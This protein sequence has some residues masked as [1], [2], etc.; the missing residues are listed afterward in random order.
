MPNWLSD[1]SS[2]IDFT[3]AIFRWWGNCILSGYWKSL[4]KQSM[5]MDLPSLLISLCFC[6]GFSFIYMFF[7][8]RLHLSSGKW[9]R[10]HDAAL[11]PQISQGNHYC[12][13]FLERCLSEVRCWQMW[14]VHGSHHVRQ[15]KTTG[16]LL[17]RELA[18]ADTCTLIHMK[19]YAIWMR[20]LCQWLCN[21]NESSGSHYW[22]ENR[23]FSMLWNRTVFW[24]LS[25]QKCN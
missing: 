8:D 16:V 22:C 17:W 24:C 10:G 11:C 20:Y 9:D 21:E 7:F 4:V 14:V 18:H 12:F 5:V 6:S 19:W 3:V 2:G 13:L 25:W 15:R 23:G 1:S